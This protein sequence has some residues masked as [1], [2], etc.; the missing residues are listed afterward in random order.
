MNFSMSEMTMPRVMPILVR[1]TTPIITT[2]HAIAISVNF[3]ILSPPVYSSHFFTS[4]NAFPGLLLYVT[5]PITTSEVLRP[6][7]AKTEA[8]PP[9]IVA[10]PISKTNGPP[11][12]F[13]KSVIKSGYVDSGT[14]INQSFPASIG[15]AFNVS[16]TFQGHAYYFN[17]IAQ[18]TL[19][20]INSQSVSVST[21]YPGENQFLTVS[22]GQEGVLLYPNWEITL[23]TDFKENYTITLNGG[24]VKS[25]AVDGITNIPLSVNGTTAT[26]MVSLGGKVYTYRNEFIANIPLQKYYGPKG[27]QNTATF[28][29]IIF[30]LFKGAISV[31]VLGIIAYVS[32]F[33]VIKARKNRKPIVR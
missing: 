14:I 27:P 24:I 22:N 25:G 3:P 9:I 33:P 29:D 18:N 1:T 28:D 7:M 10:I 21:S 13:M 17:D 20:F 32:L 30:G 16:I 5:F 23:R 19:S 2:K 26:I 6:E 31:S 11:M 15:S 8:I 12:E 4:F